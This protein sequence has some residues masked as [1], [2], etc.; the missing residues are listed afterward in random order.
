VLQTDTMHAVSECPDTRGGLH[1]TPALTPHANKDA[2]NWL[3]QTA[4]KGITKR[5]KNEA[6]T[7][8]TLH[9]SFVTQYHTH[10]EK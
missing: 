7:A 10:L 4:M 6:L 3:Q 2:V 1:F 5:K 9:Q 8:V